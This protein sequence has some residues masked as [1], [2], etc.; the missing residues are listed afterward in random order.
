MALLGPSFDWAIP[1][2][3]RPV[4]AFATGAVGVG[5]A[6]LAVTLLMARRPPRGRRDLLLI[7]CAGLAARALLLPGGPIL[8]DDHYRYLWDGAVSAR[9]LDPYAYPPLRFLRD[10][11][12]DALLA[13]LDLSPTPL[14]AAY[15]AIARDGRPVLGR[16]NNPHLTTVYPPLAQA[17]F[18]LGHSIAPWQ[19]WGW[20][21]VLIAADATTFSFLLAALAAL[22]RPLAWSA[23][24]WLNPLVL[25]E[26]G[27]SGHMDALLMPALA[28]ALW[29]LAARREAWMAGALALAAA[30]KLWPLALLPPALGSSRRAIG[31]GIIAGA[32]TLLLVAPQLMALTPES[33]LARYAG[34]WQRNA[35]A[36][37]V[38][39][40]AFSAASDDPGMLTR[41]AVAGSV[42]GAALWFGRR[43]PL[44]PL[45]TIAA[46]GTVTALIVLLGPTGYPWYAIW[47]L[48]FAALAPDRLWLLIV[49]C[50]PAYYLRFHFEAVGRADLGGVVPPLLTF[51]PAW[52]LIGWRALR[53]TRK[54]G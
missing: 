27:N 12:V 5:L 21:L 23:I 42:I 2:G 6:F 31:I 13:R 43:H 3:G 33:G 14:P 41:I 25:K 53:T 40:F 19:L 54:H 51:G 9:G 15:D 32:A 45:A 18:A 7:V 46:L 36:F 17:G 52:A 10:D 34:E 8:E 44:D 35:L 11:R 37:P 29:M 30:I 49:A 47:L 50:A 48:P 26:F 24:Y 38:I 16:I 20:K 1:L 28:A 22:R 39:E 4:V